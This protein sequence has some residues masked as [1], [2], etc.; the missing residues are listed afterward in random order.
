MIDYQVRLLSPQ[1]H[2]FE[3][4]CAI[5]KPD[6][7][8]QR[9]SLPAWIPGSY[10][11]RDFARHIMSIEAH[12]TGKAVAIKKLD[13]HTWHCEPCHGTLEIRYIV[14]AYEISV[15]AAY[16]D[17]TRG[18]FNGTSLFLRVDGQENSPQRVKLLPHGKWHVATALPAIK[19][20]KQG[21]G[22]YQAENYD[23]LID[24]PVE[25][26]E[27][28]VAE[29]KACGVP[30]RLVVCG[31]H[32]AD[33]TRISR[34]LK[35]IC[36][37]HIQF[38]GKPAPFERYDFLLYAAADDQ[39]GG[40]EHRNSTSLICPRSWLPTPDSQVDEDN[41][42]D[43]LG[44]CSHEYFHAWH[45]KRIRPQS[46]MDA[47]ADLGRE[48]YTRLLWVFEGF[49]AYYDSLALA[50]CGLLTRQQYLEHLGRDITRYLRTPGRH[51]QPLEDSSF[52]AWIKLYRPDENSPNAQISY[53]LKGSLTA[54]ALDLHLRSTGKTSLDD[55]MQSLWQQ[56]GKT[57]TGLPEDSM[58]KLVKS[59]GGTT[60]S[61]LLKLAVS[62]TTDLP[63]DKLLEKFGVRY[64]L[65]AASSDG[66]KGG[67]AGSSSKPRHVLGIKLA[68]GKEAKLASVFTGG[69]AEQ[70]GLA[71]GDVIIAIDGLKA[72]AGNL[73]KLVNANKKALHIHAFRRDELME[74]EVTP[75]PAP[76]D[77]CYLTLQPKPSKSAVALL[78]GWLGKSAT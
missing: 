36:E 47:D 58:E 37:H 7:A 29:F 10:L 2:Q 5:A 72:S 27:F 15:R 44:L 23:Q 1:A 40:L 12:C 64:Q 59:L 8:G 77:T 25:M 61:K 51:V 70:A 68:G 56:Y 33:L 9:L 35:R 42:A 49:T 28:A 74:F 69:A 6:K 24:S 62:D 46:L 45:V 14:Y 39:Y 53:Y 41:Y 43:F 52:D 57:G 63:L 34:D 65:R 11:V 30:H 32:N 50:R 13:K 31:R 3:I 22:S 66:D 21:F 78:D 76:L 54:L 19:T 20:D 60:A 17:T 67:K 73:E 4:I 48:A 71:G 38:F 55:I 75:Q 16:L 26:G 18:Y